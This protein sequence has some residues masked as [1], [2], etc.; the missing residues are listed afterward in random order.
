MIKIGVI[1]CGAISERKHLPHFAEC[2][3]G[4]VVA[5]ADI[6]E[7]RAREIAAKFGVKDY[8]SD[9]KEVLR[10]DDIEAVSI[11]TPNFLHGEMAV[12][13]AK[14]G[15]H[16]LVEKPIA[17]SLKAAGEMIEAAK[18]NKVILMVQQTQRF[19]PRVQKVEELIEE[20]I[21]GRINTVRGRIGNPGPEN[22]SPAGKWFFK[23]KEAFGGALADVGIHVIDL[24]RWIIKKEIKEVSAFLGTLE[25]KIEVEDNG[26]CLFRFEDGCLGVL[27]ASWTTKPGMAQVALYGEKGSMTVNLWGENPLTVNLSSGK[28]LAPEIPPESRYGTPFQYFLDCIEK[29]EEPFISGEEGKKSLEVILAAYESGAA[30]RIVNL[31]LNENR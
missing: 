25:K 10:R 7:E 2:S 1:G 3:N 22:W 17:T 9:W 27:E 26:I 24:I 13:A 21:I 5:V 19:S 8:Y 30:R 31:P 29:G 18:E 20:G 6:G 11:A 4:E 16:V 23:R 15:K 12:T 14:A 28:K